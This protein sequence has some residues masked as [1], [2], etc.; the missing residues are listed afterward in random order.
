M[1]EEKD[2]TGDSSLTECQQRSVDKGLPKEKLGEFWNW[3]QGFEEIT[4]EAYMLEHETQ[5]V[6]DIKTFMEETK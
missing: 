2:E 3:L 5:V 1:Q 4:E 6:E